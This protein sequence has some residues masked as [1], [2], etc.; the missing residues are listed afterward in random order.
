MKRIFT[1]TIL[2]IV[3]MLFTLG[4]YNIKSDFTF[5]R[6]TPDQT[7]E[8]EKKNE[9][10]EKIRNREDVKTARIA[11]TRSISSRKKKRSR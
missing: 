2:F 11:R 1:F 8:Q 4:V 10:L 3:L 5:E 9:E 6:Q 7:Q